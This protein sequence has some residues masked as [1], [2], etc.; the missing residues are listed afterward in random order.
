VTTNRLSTHVLRRL[1]RVCPTRALT[2]NSNFDGDGQSSMLSHGQVATIQSALVSPSACS[3]RVFGMLLLCTGA[4]ICSYSKSGVAPQS[5]GSH[6]ER[7]L[8]GH[9][10]PTRDLLSRCPPTSPL[11]QFRS[12]KEF[13]RFL[14]SASSTRSHAV[15]QFGTA[16]RPHL[17]SRSRDNFC[18]ML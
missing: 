4:F 12:G 7:M 11:R 14:T 17:T 1:S 16:R 15:P 5:V 6:I 2:L 9:W 10:R 13:E 18:K 3:V 8:F